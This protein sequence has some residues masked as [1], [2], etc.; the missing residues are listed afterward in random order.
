[1]VK[2][3]TYRGPSELRANIEAYCWAAGLWCN[4]ERKEIRCLLRARSVTKKN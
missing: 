1:M 3:E 2:T 4:E